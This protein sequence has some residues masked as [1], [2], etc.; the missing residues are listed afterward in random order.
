M[1]TDERFKHL[2]SDPRFKTLRKKQRKVQ[3]DERFQ[4]MFTDEKFTLKYSKDKRGRSR[5]KTSGDDLKRYYSLEERGQRD[6]KKTDKSE[7]SD[8]DD[9]DED[10]SDKI[11]ND[12]TE[13]EGQKSEV[14]NSDDETVG[15][16]DEQDSDSEL[17]TSSDEPESDH[18]FFSDSGADEDI[19][20]N[21]INY[22]WQPLDHDAETADT[23]TRRLAIQNLDWDHLDV[24]DIY[25]LVNSIRPPLSVRIYVS[26]FG[27]ERLAREEAQG[28]V[29]LVEVSKEDEE[30]EEL[31][32]LEAKMKALQEQNSLVKTY[33]N[34]E[35]EDADEALD[36][37]NEE[38]RERIRRYQL[39]R[40]KYYYA[41]AEF[42]SVESAEAVYKELDGLEYEGSSL[43]L[44][45]RF[46]PDDMEF[47]PSEIKAECDKMPDLASYKAPQFINSA[48]QQTTVKFTWDETDIKRQEKLQR[49]YT[50]EELEKDDLEAY[51]ASETD[52]EDDEPAINDSDTVSVVTANSE[53]RVNKYKML[54][55]SLEE[56]DQRK[57]KVDVDVEWGEFEQDEQ[58]VKGRVDTRSDDEH[59]G[60]VGESDDAYLEEMDGDDDS[61]SVSK[62][63]HHKSK[64]GGRKMKRKTQD[65][66]RA[67]AKDTRGY[68]R[69]QAGDDDNLD[70]L[71]MDVSAQHKDEFKFNP[72]DDRFRA[73]YESGLYNI[74]PSHPNFK[75]TEAFDQI[76]KIKRAKR[77][78][79]SS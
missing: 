28:P 42:D 59:I 23:T 34:N 20:V 15:N 72:D 10:G 78:K 32:Q 71:V 17:S 49:A 43:E 58:A 22:D 47:D 37:K 21:R 24:R 46:V 53:A 14:S 7:D 11:E 12:S 25:T 68:G 48:L 2:V 9:I 16:E 5:K 31:K 55:K 6:E 13:S 41:V 67:N 62:S 44:D 69:E 35:Y 30:E 63:K 77:Q 40:M 79:T 19:D 50:K 54:L 60:G 8:K 57:K 66:K 52:S 27:K 76:A 38:I 4:S 36:P 56:E 64:K 51:L 65:K 29:E 74:D 70:L 73:V 45:L 39:S 61:E 18:D 26:E 33:K 3:I 1:D 75:R